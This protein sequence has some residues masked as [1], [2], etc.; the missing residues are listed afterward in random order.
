MKLIKLTF[1][2][3]AISIAPTAFSSNVYI[4]YQ[5]YFD[6]ISVNHIIYP[7]F[8]N[9]GELT[10][11][12]LVDE[13]GYILTVMSPDGDTLDNLESEYV[14]D[15]IETYYSVDNDTL[16]IY[17]LMPL[18]S[19]TPYIYGTREPFLI[20][21]YIY[22]GSIMLDTTITPLCNATWFYFDY[23]TVLTSFSGSLELERDIDCGE[24]LVVFHAC[25]TYSQWIATMGT[26][27]GYEYTYKRYTSDLSQ[28]VNSSNVKDR[29]YGYFNNTAA[30][31]YGYYYDWYEV[32]V[33]DPDNGYI[34]QGRVYGIK[35]NDTTVVQVNNANV[36]YL[37]A[38]DFIENVGLDEFICFGVGEDL[39]GLYPS[40]AHSACYTFTDGGVPELAWYRSFPS[41]YEPSIY[42]INLNRIFGVQ[43][44][45]LLMSIDCAGGQVVDSTPISAHNYDRTRLFNPDNDTILKLFGIYEDSLFVFSFDSSTDIADDNDHNPIPSEFSLGQNY[46]NPFNLSTTIKYSLPSRSDVTFAVYNLLGRK[47]YTRNFTDQ[48]A[49]DYTV[50][51][52]GC[53]RYGREVASGIYFYLLKSG[54]F[55]DSK[56]M[57]LLK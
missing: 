11:I 38:G 30:F 43:S 28:S 26:W 2:L 46:P 56:K 45:S 55:T 10:E 20:K 49:G 51:W 1:L 31:G 14:I 12:L 41:G 29:V 13:T 5:H 52:N 22:D 48:P 50:V 54:E 39:T 3:L 19:H 34:H 47:I 33:D 7:V 35:T 27:D 9:N 36:S 4:S 32:H 53:D 37:F 21:K 15:D 6:S 40:Q 44:G 24:R 23:E 18:F 42:M 17:A 8:D 16:F 57:L 25:L